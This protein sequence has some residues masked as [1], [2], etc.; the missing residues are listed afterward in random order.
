MSWKKNILQHRTIRKIIGFSFVGVIAT[1]VSMALIYIMNECL[2]WNPYVSYII[3]TVLS[4]LLS[5]VLN[6]LKVFSSRFS[7]KDLGLYYLTYL[8]SMV[9]GIL[10]LRFYEWLLPTWNATLLSYMVIPITMV[11]NYFFVAKLAKT[12]HYT[13]E[14]DTKDIKE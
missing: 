5:Y 9:L 4:I 7:W 14:Q 1:L 12:N 10:L 6:M 3:S 2:H 8:S 11:Y 13:N